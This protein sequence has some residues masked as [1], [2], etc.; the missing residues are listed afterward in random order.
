MTP[1]KETATGFAFPVEVQA[2]HTNNP[3]DLSK[4]LMAFGASD[5]VV[6]KW[7]QPMWFLRRLGKYSRG[8]AEFRGEWHLAEVQNVR[9]NYQRLPHIP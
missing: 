9:E 2:T 3:F 6:K 5:P 1:S 4:P 7:W 8:Q